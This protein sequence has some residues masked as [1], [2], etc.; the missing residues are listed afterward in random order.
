MA[1]K[2]VWCKEEGSATWDHTRPTV[3]LWE[4]TS[5][6]HILISMCCC[7]IFIL[8]WGVKHVQGGLLGEKIVPL[9]ASG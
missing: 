4:D 6:S 3:I 7:H 1:T 8:N 5:M 9:F 2:V